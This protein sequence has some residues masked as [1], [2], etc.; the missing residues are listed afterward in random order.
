M[1]EILR[2]LVRLV[3]PILVFTAE[4]IWQYLPKNTQDASIASV[5]CAPWPQINPVYAAPRAAG[6]EDIDSELN[7]I[8]GLIPDIAKALEEKRTAGI[9]GS[10]FDARINLLT[11]D[12]NRY[13]YLASLQDELPE[14]FKVSQVSVSTAEA[15]ACGACVSVAY[16]DIAITVTKALGSKCP[17]CWN[18]SDSIGSHTGHAA[19]CTKCVTAIGG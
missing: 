15:A 2:V 1:Y 4:E 13:T 17:R 5:H 16:P 6:G 10:S 7:V 8:I 18:Y 3:A 19:L 14:I 12:Q 11:K 9:I